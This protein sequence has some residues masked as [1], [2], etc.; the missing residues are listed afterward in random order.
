MEWSK[1]PI[2]RVLYT[3]YAAAVFL[4]LAA[5]ILFICLHHKNTSFASTLILSSLV[6]TLTVIL[7]AT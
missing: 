7:N 6:L 2:L 5:V 1:L 3:D 4:I